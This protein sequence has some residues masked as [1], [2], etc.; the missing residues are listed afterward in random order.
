M[1]DYDLPIQVGVNDLAF[2][3]PGDRYIVNSS[4]LGFTPSFS[5]FEVSNITGTT[6]DMYVRNMSEIPEVVPEPPTL[7]LVG[8]GLAILGIFSRRIRLSGQ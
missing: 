2:F 1:F 3:H 5:M 8:A 7:F 4:V 6:V